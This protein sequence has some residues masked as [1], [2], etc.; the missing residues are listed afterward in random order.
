M[1]A[2]AEA[3]ARTLAAMDAGSIEKVTE[4]GDTDGG[5][6]AMAAAAAAPVRKPIKAYNSAGQVGT[7]ELS[8]DEDEDEATAGAAAGAGAEP[9]EPYCWEEG[10]DAEADTVKR[11]RHTVHWAGYQVFYGMEFAGEVLAE[12]F[13]LN[14]SKFQDILDQAERDKQAE[15]ERLEHEA[16]RAELRRL[17]R[18]LEAEEAAAAAAAAAEGG[19]SGAGAGSSA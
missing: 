19:A 13:G 9:V 18:E 4:R 8:E 16:Q 6:A 12:F 17:A 11:L 10:G 1:S 2:G 15:K 3:A 5:E 7:L 14:K